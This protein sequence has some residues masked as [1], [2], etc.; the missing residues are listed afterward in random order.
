MTQ[1]IE[2]W[3][4]VEVDS[5]ARPVQVEDA[6]RGL[7]GVELPNGKGLLTW[8][9]GANARFAVVDSPEKW[10]EDDVVSSPQALT[11]FSSG[12]VFRV[13]CGLVGSALIAT[14]QRV[15]GTE[16]QVQLWQAN[17]VLNPSSWTLRGNVQQLV[18]DGNASPPDPCMIAGVPVIYGGK[19]VLPG[20]SFAN[21]IGSWSMRAGVWTSPNGVAGWSRVVNQGYATGGR[22][23]NFQSGQVGI[24]PD[25]RLVWWSST[26]AEGTVAD[27]RHGWRS[28]LNDP[29]TWTFKF[30]SLDDGAP[31]FV[32]FPI[33]VGGVTLVQQGSGVLRWSETDPSDFTNWTGAVGLWRA[34]GGTSTAPA[35]TM[36]AVVTSRGVYFFWLDRVSFISKRT[37]WRIGRIGM[38]TES[39]IVGAILMEDGTAILME[40][41]TAILMEDT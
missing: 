33:R 31:G 21:D 3:T 6:T 1:T 15:V 32:A 8:S 18:L 16:G 36:R 22:F 4:P 14:I 29:D 28:A 19:W 20:T 5:Y 2:R 10:V 12:T 30:R 17:S 38:R 40:D 24:D 39:L 7:C 41:G 11:S 34:D 13:A 25:G 9:T 35:R 26:D 37:L 27:S 23:L